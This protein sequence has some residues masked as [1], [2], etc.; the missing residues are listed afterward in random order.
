MS[1]TISYKHVA[2][3]FSCYA[4]KNALPDSN[5]YMEHFILLELHGDNNVTTINPYSRREVGCQTLDYGSNR[6]W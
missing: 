5:F 1:H 6:G 3:Q 4:L 2:I